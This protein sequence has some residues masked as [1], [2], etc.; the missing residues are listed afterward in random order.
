MERVGVGVIS[1][2]YE[3]K[4]LGDIVK[5]EGVRRCF[6]AFLGGGKAVLAF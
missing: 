2:E 1:P 5:V 4:I 6:G 3:R